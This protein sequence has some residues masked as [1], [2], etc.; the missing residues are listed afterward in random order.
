[1]ISVKAVYIG[2]DDES[3]IQNGLTKAVNIITSDENHVGK[4]IVMQSMMYA[5]GSDAL[6]PPSFVYKRYVFIVDIDV[7]GR[8]MSILRSRDYFVVN[9][10][11]LIVPLEGKGAF[12][13]YWSQHISPLPTIVKDGIPKLVG[14]TLFLQMAF[15]PQASRNTSRVVGGYFDKNDFTE[16]LYAV[17]GLDARQMDSNTEAEL[18]RRKAALETRKRELVKQSSSLRQVGTS[19]A[20]ISPTADR[21]ETARLVAELDKIKNQIADQKKQRNHAYTRMKK[22]EAVLT[23]LRSLNRE[24]KVGSVVCLECGSEA[25]GYKM[26]S[27]DFAF[28]ITTD[29]MRKQILLAV[30]EKID[31]YSSDIRF[32]ER[33]IRELQSRFNALANQREITL[34]DIYAARES[35]GDIE[36]IDGELTAVCD[37]IDEIKERLKDSKR[38]DEELREE[39]ADFK[40]M[41]LDT[42]NSVRKTV[43][44]DPSA[45]EYTD[46]F[47][48]TA[49]QYMGSEATEFFIARV[50][51]LAKHVQHGLPVLIDS[52]RAEEL[53]S[54][55][56]ERA[57]PFFESL[58]NQIILTATLKGEEAGKYRNVCGI[59]NIDFAGYAE[60]KLLS[61]A[62][63]QAF[64]VKVK[65]FGVEL[66][67]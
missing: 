35:Y 46:L 49:S 10:G 20:A 2:N 34:E 48:T 67:I 43:N 15:V 32:F 17:V 14:L 50:Y 62:Y 40:A 45:E 22:N 54:A 47:T 13:E 65:T 27:S 30:Q 9:D 39:R 23:E 33:E 19:L 64:K 25:I 44:D 3:Y 42:M 28:D 66:N 51:S 61:E 37:E 55:R 57:L 56:E 21:E 18:K 41:I 5:M 58:P 24:I 1:M 52:F 31:A 6:F 53:S 36:K 63:N 16:M 59:N 38:V 60:N 7:D 12:D 8:E 29:D 26:P 4:T 11:G